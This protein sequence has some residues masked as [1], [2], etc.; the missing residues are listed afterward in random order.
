MQ[1]MRSRRRL[2]TRLGVGIAITFLA[3]QFRPAKGKGPMRKARRG[4]GAQP[5][6]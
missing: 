5:R 3:A 2:V 4:A 1:Q 6:G